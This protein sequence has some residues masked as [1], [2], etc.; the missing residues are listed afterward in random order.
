[1]PISHSSF[2][3][4]SILIF[5]LIVIISSSFNF[6]IKINLISNCNTVGGDGC[7]ANC[8]VIT[9]GFV[10]SGGS[11]TVKDTWVQC[12]TGFYPNSDKT[13]CVTQWGDSI[14]AGSEGWDDSNSSSG[15]GCSSSCVVENGFKCSGGSLYS[16]DT[17]TKCA[18]GY[19]TN[20]S[21]TTQC[22]TKWGDGIRVG[23]EKCD[24]GNLA[25]GD[26]WTY[27]WIIEDGYVWVGGEFGVTDVWLQCDMGYDP[28]PDFSVCVGATVPL[29]AK[30]AA[31]ASVN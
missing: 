8:G 26:G 31:V 6:K 22:I 11:I 3:V 1:M 20:F 10:C 27:Q 17:W 4:W 14:K 29:D 30:S 7:E 21:D 2:T 19:Y 15:D 18:K 25:D 23:S 5:R 16:A 12:T 9:T 13:Q 28:N 24:D